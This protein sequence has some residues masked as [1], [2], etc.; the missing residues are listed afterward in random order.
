MD[1]KYL[2]KKITPTA[3]MLHAAL[4]MQTA[5]ASPCAKPVYKGGQ[6]DLKVTAH[7]SESDYKSRYSEEAP[8]AIAEAAQA[9]Y[10]FDSV[11]SDEREGINVTGNIVV[12][13]GFLEPNITVPFVGMNVNYSGDES[14]GKAILNLNNVDLDKADPNP[15][16]PAADAYGQSNN[17]SNYYYAGESYYPIPY[18]LQDNPPMDTGTT[19]TKIGTG[20]VLPAN[21]DVA[22]YYSSYYEALAAEQAAYYSSPKYTPGA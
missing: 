13:R 10:G 14:I 1:K 3:I 20:E 8:R 17:N 15:C 9:K 6:I 4:S 19:T 22:S 18:I 5:V 21:A 11:A 2:F 7:M 16:T 12:E